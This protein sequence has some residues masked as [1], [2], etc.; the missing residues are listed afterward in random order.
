MIE[1]IY[2]EHA[3]EESSKN[4]NRE[5]TK[6]PPPSPKRLLGMGGSKSKQ[7]A[8]AKWYPI[9]VYTLY[10]AYLLPCIFTFAIATATAAAAALAFRREMMRSG[11]R[12][13]IRLCRTSSHTK[14]RLKTIDM[15]RAR[16]FL[17]KSEYIVAD[18]SRSIP[19]RPHTFYRAVVHCMHAGIRSGK[20][21]E[22][23]TT[24]N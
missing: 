14:E 22:K 19:I 13:A 23:K 6:L 7:A 24:W 1:Y 16:R 21:K 10:N 18:V 4:R 12:K 20:T 2:R 5:N 17:F 8:N 3:N 11:G 9:S 15:K